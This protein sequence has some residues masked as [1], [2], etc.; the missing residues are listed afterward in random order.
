MAGEDYEALALAALG[1]LVDSATPTE[2]GLA[3]PWRRN[4]DPDPSLYR[5]A[6][7]ICF[8]L[9][10]ARRAGP[11]LDRAED[12]YGDL[13]LRT[14]R[15]LS[16]HVDEV[17]QRHC[18]LYLGLTGLAV[19]LHAVGEVLGDDASSSEARR[20][21]DLVRS[22]FDGERWGEQFELLG[23]NAGIALGALQVGDDDPASGRR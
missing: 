1:W 6:A 10:E 20:A 15:Q 4:G 21:L 11:R 2:A 12:D 16:R 7:G 23:G 13:A 8:A 22:R 17:G 5:G 14:A 3:W 9:L 18:G 19:A